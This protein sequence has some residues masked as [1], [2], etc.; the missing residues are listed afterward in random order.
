MSVQ[1][2]VVCWL[3]PFIQQLF[4]VMTVLRNWTYNQSPHLT[5]VTT[6]L[7]SKFGHL[8]ISLHLWLL[9]CMQSY[10]LAVH[11]LPPLQP[12]PPIYFHHHPICFFGHPVPHSQDEDFTMFC[13]PHPADLPPCPPPWHSVPPWHDLPF[14]LAGVS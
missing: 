13:C 3:R 4:K 9:Q 2:L 10:S 12:Y 1:V 5:I 8:A 6:S 11:E 7:Y 14:G